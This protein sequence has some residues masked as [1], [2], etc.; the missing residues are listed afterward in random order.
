VLA[1]EQQPVDVALG[2]LDR[3][4][5]TTSRPATAGSR[6]AV[7]GSRSAM[8]AFRPA[9]AASRLAVAGFRP[10]MAGSRFAVAA[11]RWLRRDDGVVRLCRHD[12]P[13]FYRSNI[14]PVSHACPT[15]HEM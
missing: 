11:S 3:R 4:G 14:S 15:A 8:A 6:L 5:T 2:E 7:A 10:A 1:A 9:M 13:K 12:V